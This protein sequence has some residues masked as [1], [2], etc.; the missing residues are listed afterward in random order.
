MRLSSLVLMLSL[1]P[2]ASWSAGPEPTS[3]RIAATGSDIFTVGIDR[4]AASP[5]ALH[6]LT[7]ANLELDS[8]LLARSAPAP[9]AGVSEAGTKITLAALDPGATRG[10]RRTEMRRSEM[11]RVT[12]STAA[13]GS[14]I[15]ST[16][17]PLPSAWLMGFVTIG[18]IGYQLRRKHRLL[19]PQRFSF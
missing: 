1:A 2:V 4:A 3:I 9:A 11:S 5:A 8:P 18:L 13:P 10:L 12:G 17:E 14:S 6:G 16:Q 7:A 15:A 19:R